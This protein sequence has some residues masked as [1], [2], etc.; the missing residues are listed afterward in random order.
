MAT[1]SLVLLNNWLLNS[2]SDKKHST[3]EKYL[4]VFYLQK[5]IPTIFLDNQFSDFHKITIYFHRIMNKLLLQCLLNCLAIP[6][7]TFHYY[8]EPYS[9]GMWRIRSYSMIYLVM[10]MKCSVWTGAPMESKL[11]VVVEIGTL[12]CTANNVYVVCM[13]DLYSFSRWRRWYLSP[14][15]ICNT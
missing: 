2:T 1:L 9:Y 3:S 10:L 7:S 6:L 13:C 8:F 11:P 15:L 14:C 4:K 12:K 5:F